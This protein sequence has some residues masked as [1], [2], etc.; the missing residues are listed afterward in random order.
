MNNYYCIFL[1]AISSQID[2]WIQLSSFITLHDT[3]TWRS[4]CHD[5]HGTTLS[6]LLLI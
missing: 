2:R 1:E 5:T 3:H 4:Q 6:T